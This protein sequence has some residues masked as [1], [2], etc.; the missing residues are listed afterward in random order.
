[1]SNIPKS[2][3]HNSQSLRAQQ[4]LN[5]REEDSEEEVLFTSQCLP[6]PCIVIPT[7]AQMPNSMLSIKRSR[8]PDVFETSIAEHTSAADTVAG[9]DDLLTEILL[10]LPIRSL[11][12]FKSVSK[13]WLSLIT[14]PHFCLRRNPHP[15]PPS[16]LFL[17]RSSRP[18]NP[19]FEW[20]PLDN[21]QNPTNN[22]PFS[23]LTFVNDTSGITIL[24]S[25]NGLLCCRSFRVR[26]PK[27][28][29]YIYNPTTKQFTT[30]PRPGGGI[31][32]TIHGVNLAFDPS[33][34]PHYKVVCVRSSELV[35]EH[36]QIE[37]YSPDTGPWRV[38]GRPFTAHFDTQFNRGVY[39]NGAIH[40]ISSWEDSLYFNVDEE[41][42]ETMLM[43]LVP[44]GWDERRFGYFGES[45]DHLHLVEIYGPSTSRFNVYEMERDYSK[46]FVKFRVDLDPVSTVFPE[47]IRSHLHPWDLR[48]FSFVL[49]SLVRGEKDEDSFVVLHITGKAIR[50]NFV[51]TTFKKL[52]D[53]APSPHDIEGFSGGEDLTI[54]DILEAP[55]E[56]VGKSSYGTLYR[57]S[58]LKINSIT[59]LR[60]L[61]P[62][63]TGR[64]KEVVPAIQFLGS[65]RHPNLVPLR[66]FYAGPKGEKLLVYPFYG[67]GTLAQ[68]IR[69]GNGE[70]RKWAII[71]RISI[72]IVRGLDHLHSGL[73]RPVIHGNL[74]SKNILLDRNYQPCVS[75]FGLYL[76]LNPTAGQEMLEAS[77]AQGYKAPELIKMK[78][79]SEE[80][81]IYSLGVI[82]LEILTG[83]EPIIENSPPAQDVYLPNSMRN[84]ILDNRIADLYHPDILLGQNS[85]ESPVTEER[86]LKFFQLAMACCSPS[87][88]LRPDIK[89]VLRKLQEMGD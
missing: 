23:S 10:R 3:L 73:E 9:N 87:P 30:L 14:N 35:P 31:S 37:I 32:K 72:G 34:S 5:R 50:Y 89:Q 11:I 46:W 88:S 18:T 4:S 54:H 6:C 40:W 25:C 36:Y 59:L 68:F 12:R 81:D 71:H 83:K 64:P 2:V 20:V 39:W 28:S 67:R 45:R 70:S 44:D 86:I 29:Y 15:N 69:D 47:M 78:D 19:K 33:K 79:A 43:P 22:A 42:L 49:L 41:R 48:Y 21:T 85:D 74:K 82:L 26:E 16:G 52:C 76:L 17:H 61:R 80:T 24:Q 65:I 63:C 27:S 1:M 62:A 53:F 13:H 77:E 60:F 57:A 84:A 55:G 8:A 75:D 66:A 58:L 51:D 7:V 38:S 56:V